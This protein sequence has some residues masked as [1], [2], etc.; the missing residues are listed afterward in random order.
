[1]APVANYHV[2]EDEHHRYF[3]RHPYQGY[4][5][6]V[7]APKVEAFQRSFPDWVDHAAR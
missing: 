7:V 2:A 5:A 4:C 6:F 3:D 1:M